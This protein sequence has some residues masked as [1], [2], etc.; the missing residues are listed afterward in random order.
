[1]KKSQV[2]IYIYEGGGAVTGKCLFTGDPAKEYILI[3]RAY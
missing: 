1:M 2:Y 3:A